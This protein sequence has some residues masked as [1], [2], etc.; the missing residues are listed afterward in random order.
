MRGNSCADADE[1]A[2]GCTVGE[3][4]PWQQ[5]TSKLRMRK[6]EQSLVSGER[7]TH[8]WLMIQRVHRAIAIA[9]CRCCNTV[10]GRMTQAASPHT[11]LALLTSY[12]SCLHEVCRLHYS[13][14]VGQLASVY[15][16]WRPINAI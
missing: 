14:Y 15:N 3:Q 8:L 6:I 9:S 13:R 7:D 4:L 12:A 1:L 10:G 11:H 2:T 16:N 5:Q